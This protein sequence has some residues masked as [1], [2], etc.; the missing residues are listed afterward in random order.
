MDVLGK[1]SIADIATA[2]GFCVGSAFVTYVIRMIGYFNVVGPEFLG[3][4]L[5]SDLVQGAIL[6]LPAVVLVV[7]LVLVG[8]GWVF[9]TMA[10]VAPY[11]DRATGYLPR[12]FQIDASTLLI[13]LAWTSSIALMVINIVNPDQDMGLLMFFH[14]INFMACAVF[15][16]EYFIAHERLSLFWAVVLM[17]NAYWCIYQFGR[18]E[19]QSDINFSKNRYTIYATDKTFV[20][21]SLLRSTS[22][23][24]LLKS[25]DDVVLYDRSQVIRIERMPTIE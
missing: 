2:L 13:V 24:V 18:F 17:L 23:A 21:V 9:P 3:M 19:A 10:R 11:V 22:K 20:N 8:V 16:A 14:M 1:Y 15:A 4:Y 12:A 25:G 7:S 6:A 5:D